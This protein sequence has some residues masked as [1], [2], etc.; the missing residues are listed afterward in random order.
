MLVGFRTV[1]VP[2]AGQAGYTAAKAGV[3]GF[4]LIAAMMIVPVAAG[5]PGGAQLPG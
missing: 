2:A 1:Q 4:L 5:I 3:L